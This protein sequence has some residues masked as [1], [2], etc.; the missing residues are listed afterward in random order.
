MSTIANAAGVCSGRRRKAPSPDRTMVAISRLQIASS[1][2]SAATAGS[3][4][5]TPVTGGARR[6]AG[7]RRRPRRDSFVDLDESMACGDDPA[8]ARRLPQS[9][10]SGCGDDDEYF[11]VGS[12]GSPRT[13]TTGHSAPR[14][15]TETAD[16]RLMGTDMPV[17]DSKMV[18][19]RAGREPRRPKQRGVANR[20][21]R[22]DS[23]VDLAT[24]GTGVSEDFAQAC[25]SARNTGTNASDTAWLE[26]AH[27]VSGDGVDGPIV[28][29]A[30]SL[31]GQGATAAAGRAHARRAKV[32][33]A[34]RR[35]ACAASSEVDSSS[36]DE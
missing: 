8:M 2:T 5:V 9:G 14:S 10:I 17:A 22:R 26:L 24:G 23:W 6:P 4:A 32:R 7:H 35:R 13:L 33:A 11:A 29:I 21:S 1:T 34:G 27:S 31:T 36:A 19:L 30:A 12:P 16:T 28:T 18:A 25:I 15:S 20:R 3:P